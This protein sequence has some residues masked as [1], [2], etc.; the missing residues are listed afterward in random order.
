[1]VLHNKFAYKMVRIV[2]LIVRQYGL[3][4]DYINVEC[5]PE[6]SRAKIM[7]KNELSGDV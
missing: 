5:I 4:L 3:S 6:Y 2:K 7:T 1:M